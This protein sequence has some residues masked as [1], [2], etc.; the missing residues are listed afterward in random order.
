MGIKKFLIC[1]CILLGGV[2]GASA[3]EIFSAD[4]PV[5][6]G[7]NVMDMSATFR[8]I[9][10]RLDS[11]RWGGKN[12]AVAIESLENLNPAAHVAVTDERVVLVWGEDRKSVV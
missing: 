11:V 1:V 5:Q 10:Q 7:L 9:Y 8:D 2:Q 6:D 3:V 4:E 12:I